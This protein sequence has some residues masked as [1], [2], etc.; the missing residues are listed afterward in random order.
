MKIRTP[1]DGSTVYYQDDDDNWIYACQGTFGFAGMFRIPVSALLTD[2]RADGGP[3]WEFLV[4]NT[5]RWDA[6]HQRT[7]G[8]HRVTRLFADQVA[9]LPAVPPVPEYTPVEWASNFQS[10]KLPVR[11]D[12]PR[13][14]ACLDRHALEHPGSPL[15]LLLVLREDEYESM[16]GDGIFLYLHWACPDSEQNLSE[17]NALKLPG[18]KLKIRRAALICKGEQLTLSYTKRDTFEHWKE[19]DVFKALELRLDPAWQPGSER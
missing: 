12:Y 17:C 2:A 3:E 6:A 5:L 1:T 16:F 13:I 9:I 8:N 14:S 18:H 10:V 15:N 7:F 4:P 19:G 11:S